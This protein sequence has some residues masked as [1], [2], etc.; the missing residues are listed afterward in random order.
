MLTIVVR[1]GAEIARAVWD[2]G[3]LAGDVAIVDTIEAMVENGST[4][5][6]TPVGPT[7]VVTLAEPRSIVRAL[8]EF[9]D[10]EVEGDWPEPTWEDPGGDV[11]Y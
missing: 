10:V 4:V 2:D 3:D 6:I 1:R 9:G 7:M 8:E 11:D 5:E